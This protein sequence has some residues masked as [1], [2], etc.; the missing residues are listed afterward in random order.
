MDFMF[1]FPP[2]KKK[3]IMLNERSQ[4]QKP[5]YCMTSIH[6][7]S[8][9]SKFIETESRLVGCQEMGKGKWGVTANGYKASFWGD[10]N[11]LELDSGDGCITL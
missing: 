10:G 9:I 11:A 5:T 1:I 2:L 4:T 3:K 6:E 7:M 8:R